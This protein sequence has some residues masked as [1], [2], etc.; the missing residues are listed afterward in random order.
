MI[1]EKY[2]KQDE[3]LYY[4]IRQLQEGHNES[5]NEIYYLSSKY[6]YK[7][8]YDIVQD[9][10]TTEDMLQET[11]LKI[12]NNIEKLQS[13]EA[14][15]VWAGRIATNLCIRYRQKY[16]KEE[17]QSPIDDGEGN[18]TFIFDTVA[19]DNEMFI[20]ESV[21]DNKEHQRLIGEVIDSLSV[22]QKLAVQCFYFEEMSVKAIAAAMECSEGTVKSRLNYARKAIKE[23]VLRIERTQG[24]KLYSLAAVPVLLVAYRYLAEVTLVSASAAVGTAGA[25]AANTSSASVTATETMMST[26]TSTSEVASSGQSTSASA[27]DLSSTS[28]SSSISA[29]SVTTEVTAT[30]ATETTV[31]SSVAEGASVTAGA[32]SATESAAIAS[33]VGSVATATTT[34]T[35]TAATVAS[36]VSGK[37]I[38]LIAA[39]AIAVG[40]TIGG[41]IAIANKAKESKEDYGE[42]KWVEYD[43]YRFSTIPEGEVLDKDGI[44]SSDY[45]ISYIGSAMF[46]I[47]NCHLSDS[48]SYDVRISRLF[49]TDIPELFSDFGYGYYDIDFI[50]EYYETLKQVGYIMGEE[51]DEELGYVFSYVYNSLLD[52]AVTKDVYEA[53]TDEEINE[54]EEQLQLK[55]IDELFGFVITT[56]SGNY[57]LVCDLHPQ[58]VEDFAIFWD[59]YPDLDYVVYKNPEDDIQ[60]KGDEYYRFWLDL[61]A[62]V[63]KIE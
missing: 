13:P 18:E 40:G 63:Y 52:Y 46:S 47:S 39:G 36:G 45:E 22:D 41:G 25:V 59:E 56:E 34:T 49:N 17:I 58:W 55:V 19:D 38:A 60:I 42:W 7:I 35:A 10:H 5:F 14:F 23:T 53:M 33:S 28:T 26:S 44:L 61:S 15:Y 11:F 9:Y 37:V 8:I 62:K 32:T 50:A 24:T 54:Y 51:V 27:V 2:A 4:H 16:R 31:G 20:P 29:P 6:I 30:T 43:E 12:Y 1:N 48:D 21:M 57:L 3:L